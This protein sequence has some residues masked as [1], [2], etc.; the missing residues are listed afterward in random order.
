MISLKEL[1]EL[2]GKIMVKR[3]KILHKCLEKEGLYFGQPK[4][5]KII[6]ENFECDQ[7]TLAKELSCSKASVTCSIKR[8]EKAGLIEREVSKKDMRCNILR[9]TELG[10]EKCEI[11]DKI[12][13]DTIEKQ[14]ED[15]TDEDKD[16]MQYLFNKILNNLE[17]AYN[18]E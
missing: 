14:F 3:R 13:K 8:L 12:L 17:G 1:S 15:F 7:N 18:N 2:E 4:I 10:K 5:L 6:L 16:K 11:A 9:L